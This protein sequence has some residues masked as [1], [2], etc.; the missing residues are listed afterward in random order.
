MVE[1]VPPVHVRA[2]I[3]LEHYHKRSNIETA[4]SMIKGKFGS[5]LRSRS[6]TG[7]VNEALCKILCHNICVLIRAMHELGIEPESR[8][9]ERL[10]L[11]KIAL[12]SALRP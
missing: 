12:P 6:D 9:S 5:Y 7:Q 3:V 4:Y 10:A 2:R 11:R 8:F 1:D